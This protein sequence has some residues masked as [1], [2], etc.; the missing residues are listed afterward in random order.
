M[1]PSLSLLVAVAVI[2]VWDALAGFLAVTVFIAGV[3]IPRATLGQPSRFERCS[4]C[5]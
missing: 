2:G 5:Q 4:G 3:A 1:P